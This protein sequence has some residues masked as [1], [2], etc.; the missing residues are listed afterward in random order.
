[1]TLSSV[2]SHVWYLGFFFVARCVEMCQPKDEEEGDFAH[3]V[4]VLFKTI[5]DPCK[6]VN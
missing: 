5:I 6:T 2:L 1:M 4:S 3:D